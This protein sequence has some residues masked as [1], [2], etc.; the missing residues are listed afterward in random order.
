MLG[1]AVRF[2]TPG[3]THMTSKVCYSKSGEDTKVDKSPITSLA[4]YQEEFI[5]LISWRFTTTVAK[6]SQLLIVQMASF[7][8]REGT[9]E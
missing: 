3:S 7:P 9:L 1:F 5:S 2:L 4:E 6:N 8:G